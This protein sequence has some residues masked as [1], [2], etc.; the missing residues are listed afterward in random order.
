M[1][2]LEDLMKKWQNSA[3]ELREAERLINLLIIEN[4]RLEEMG[5]KILDLAFQGAND[6]SAAPSCCADIE[7]LLE[8]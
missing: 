5:G 6:H 3:L 8:Q 2:D 7:A 1:H 4:N